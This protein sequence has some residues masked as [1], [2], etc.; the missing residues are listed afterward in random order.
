MGNYGIFDCCR[1]CGDH[2]ATCHSG[3]S[4]YNAAI[5]ENERRKDYDRHQARTVSRSAFL[6]N[7]KSHAHS[8]YHHRPEI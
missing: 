3:C 1:F 8:R 4:R 5:A 7:A 6:G 2:S